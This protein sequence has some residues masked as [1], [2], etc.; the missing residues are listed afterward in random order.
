MQ[1][2]KTPTRVDKTTGKE[3]ILDPIIMTLSKY[4]QEAKVLKPLDSDCE[5]KGKASDH[6][7][8][9]V[10]PVSSFNNQNSR[11]TKKLEV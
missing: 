6:K 3:A 5:K 7:I 2:V 8:V 11:V 1:I 10:M 9:K 4:Y